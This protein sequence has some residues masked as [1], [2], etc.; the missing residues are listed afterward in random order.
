MPGPAGDPLASIRHYHRVD[1]TLAT[2]GQPTAAELAAVAAAGFRTVINLAL[3]TSPGALADE[4][5]VVRALGLEY[6]AIPVDFASPQPAEFRRF[7]AALES[8]AGQPVFV[9]CALNCRVSA[10]LAAHRV[11]RQGW[12]REAAL[13][14]LC[15]RWKPDPVWSAFL[16]RLWAESPPAPPGPASGHTGE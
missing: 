8:R 6:V 13:A 1:A 3:P 15:Q 7:C 9:H 2:A 10:F 11:L 5:G 14:G 12:T 4:A 16:E